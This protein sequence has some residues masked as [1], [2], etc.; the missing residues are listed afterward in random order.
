MFSLL[1]IV[2]LV[3]TLANAKPFL[4]ASRT[5]NLMDRTLNANS[6]C[7]TSG[8]TSCASSTTNGT[9]CLEAPGGLLAQTQFWDFDPATG[10]ADSWTIHGLWP[11]HCDGT[12]DQSCDSS[13]QYTD[14]A[15]ILSDNGASDV[16]S[17]MKTYW[18]DYNGD[19]A[20]FWAHEWGKHGT[21]MST[22]ELDCFGSN[23]EQGVDATA[24][25]TS[26]VNLFK[27]YTTYEWLAKHDITPSSSGTHKLSDILSALKTESGVTPAI[28]CESNSLNQ[29][30]W[31]FNLKGSAI[32]GKFVAIDAPKAGSC[33]SSGIKYPPKSGSSST[34]T[35]SDGSLPAKATIVA[36]QNGQSIGGLISKG[37]VSTQTLATFTLSGSKNSFTMTSSKG[38]CGVSSGE[39]SC[40]SSVSSSTF[41]AVTDGSNLLLAI[42]GETKF[43][44]DGTP[45]GSTA[46]EVYS[47]S[48]HSD[49]YTLSIKS[50]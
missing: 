6:G 27:S 39:L 24:Y 10:P 22:L 49:V 48:D 46:Y 37:V 15:G 30:Y 50:K 40:G 7:G 20:S 38:S 34:T 45:S 44:S 26:T 23:A 9:C 11:D 31:Y 18:K 14:I 3:A 17:D 41:S 47:G 2:S 36:L 1:P 43:S 4:A 33:P 29:I 32:D 25:F 8:G 16:L 5:M 19:D 28:D 12:Y 42:D 35:T 21:C 13:R